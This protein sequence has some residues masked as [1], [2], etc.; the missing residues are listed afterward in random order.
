MGASLA[1]ERPV[2]ALTREF[3][4]EYPDYSFCRNLAE[5]VRNGTVAYPNALVLLAKKVAAARENSEAI[6]EKLGQRTVIHNGSAVKVSSLSLGR[7]MRLDDDGLKE[8]LEFYFKHPYA[9]RRTLRTRLLPR[10]LR[11]FFL[12]VLVGHAMRREIALD[13]KSYFQMLK[14]L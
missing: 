2:E 9:H 14:M 10:W 1:R 4:R 3:F 5:N 12:S 7:A 8:V 11:S 13:Y 6:E